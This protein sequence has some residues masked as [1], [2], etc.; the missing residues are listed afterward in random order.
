M[1][2]KAGA[3]Q[4]IK[5]DNEPS[6]EEILASIR[7]IIAD[8]SLGTK[9]DEPAPKKPAAKKEPEPAPAEDEDV[10][11]LAEVAVVASVPEEVSVMEEPAP[12]P[13]PEVALEPAP[14]PVPEVM[15]EPAPM[16]QPAAAPIHNVA[17]L[18]ERII[19]ENTGSLVAQAFQT[20]SRNTPLPAPG[21]SLEDVVAELLR[22]MLRG[23]LDDHLP[24]IVE[25]MVK[26][27]IERVSRG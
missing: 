1:S 19:S 3:A 14:V 26:A 17:Q 27:E 15:L 23:W 6:M 13:V 8:D 21:R 7:K 20:L 5:D 25:K 22:P 16:P 9:K 12:E 2:A 11:D 24:G 18:E 4:E 10:L